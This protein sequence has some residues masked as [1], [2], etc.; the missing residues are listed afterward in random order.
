MSHDDL[1]DLAG[2]LDKAAE[3][4]HAETRKVVSKGALNIKR[5]WR[6]KWHRDLDLYARRLY[7]S[8]GYDLTSTPTTESAQI[9]PDAD[10]DRMQGPLGGIIEYGSVNNAPIPAGRPALEKE[11]PKFERA[12]AKMAERL[13]S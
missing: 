8:V 1:A 3:K 11:T 10:N 9:G 4:V 7:L 12:L 2:D 5:D 13:L 6:Q